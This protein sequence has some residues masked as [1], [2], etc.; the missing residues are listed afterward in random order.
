MLKFENRENVRKENSFLVFYFENCRAMISHSPHWNWKTLPWGHCM[1]QVNFWNVWITLTTSRYFDLHLPGKVS[2]S[3]CLYF[4]NIHIVCQDWLVYETWQ[5]WM[6]VQSGP[7]L[8]W[9]QSVCR[10]MASI[11]CFRNIKLCSCESAL[12]QS[13]YENHQ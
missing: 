13:V 11:N 9:W 6:N 3:Y 12:T 2:H 4:Q 5:G 10:W 1:G 7:A 8:Y